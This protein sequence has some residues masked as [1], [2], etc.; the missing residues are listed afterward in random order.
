MAACFHHVRNYSD[1]MDWMHILTS[2]TYHVGLEG[3]QATI[4]W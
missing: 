2:Q 4:G 1:I 3:G